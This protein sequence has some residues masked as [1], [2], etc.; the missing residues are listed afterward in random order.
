MRSGITRL[1]LIGAGPAHRE[2]LARLTRHH[3]ADL[4]VTLLAA[5][6]APV[7]E[8]LVPAV[9]AGRY[10]ADACRVGL[11]GLLTLAHARWVPGRCLALDLEG[12]RVHA[13]PADG[14]AALELP[15][16]LLSLD[17]AASTDR[18]ALEQ[19]LPGAREQALARYPS[20]AF[21]GLWP[22][23]VDMARERP[24]SIAVIGSGAAAI[25]L[26]FA[27]AQRLRAEGLPGSILTLLTDGGA[28][29]GELPPDVASRVRRELKRQ[30]IH[31]L[32]ERCTGIT[33]E[34]VR[35]ANGAL[36][37][38]DVPLVA[39]AAQ[40]PAWLRGTPL[41]LAEGGQV[42]VNRFQQS[43]SHPQVFAAGPAARRDDHAYPDAATT[44]A[45]AG[46]TLAHNLL[47]AFAGQP[48]KPHW[49]A[50]RPLTRLSCGT[51]CAIAAWGP[52]RAQ[53]AWVARWKDRAERHETAAPP[54][55]MDETASPTQRRHGRPVN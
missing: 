8:P 27:A 54:P 39:G 6:P 52:L 41:A 22:R 3:P 7:H 34:G 28:L 43:T 23:V 47:A 21:L 38:C 24:L 36:L 44:S 26:V 35:L 49:P 30:R 11:S 37:R 17:T 5:P 16:D 12:R 48:L 32:N 10:T 4:Q 15:F 29:A 25:E 31:V 1:V 40:A 55:L 14:G 19:R 18:E 53:G 33:V 46:A 42:L 9:V 20:E 2:V 45:R 13:A 51:E 50:Q